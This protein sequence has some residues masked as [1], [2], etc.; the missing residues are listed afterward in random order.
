MVNWAQAIQVGGIGF[1][2]VFVVLGALALAVW[3]VGLLLR[4]FAAGGSGESQ[5]KKGN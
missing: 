2:T 5:P 4:R 1:L 3:I